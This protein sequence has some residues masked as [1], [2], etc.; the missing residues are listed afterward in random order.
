MNKVKIVFVCLGNICRSPAAEAVMNSLIKKE[1]LQDR[2]V[3]DS[4]ATSGHHEGES[5]DPRTIQHAKTR[6]HNVTSISRPF[7]KRL[8]FSQ[9]DF[10]VTM[11][12]ANLGD[13]RNMDVKGVHRDKIFRLVDFCSNK[14]YKDV[15]DPYYGGPDGFETVMDILEDGCQGLLQKIKASLL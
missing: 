7:N 10:I 4:A 12:D 14:K 15:P 5:A 9:F 2:I 3:C 1:N 11:D 13:V 6:G 8:D